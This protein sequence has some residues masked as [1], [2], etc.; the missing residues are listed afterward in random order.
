MAL[1][2]AALLFAAVPS[3]V[4]SAGAAD[5]GKALFQEKCGAC[6]STKVATHKKET[7]ETWTAIVKAMQAKRANWIS[8]AQ[9]QKIVDYLSAEYGK[10]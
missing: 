9:A 7:R 8:D 5:D 10:K 2:A 6:H 3:M 4:P 1:L